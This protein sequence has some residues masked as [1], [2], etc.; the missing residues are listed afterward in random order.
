VHF[1]DQTIAN[2]G[3]GIERA[4]GLAEIGALGAGERFEKFAIQRAR[5]RL[6][7]IRAARAEHKRPRSIEDL[8]FELRCQ[9]WRG[10]PGEHRLEQLG[11]DDGDARC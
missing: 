4:L 11:G 1:P 2:P 3:G 10:H 5:R 8:C 6:A 7:V 9:L